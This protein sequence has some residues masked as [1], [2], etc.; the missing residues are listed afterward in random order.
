MTALVV[1]ATRTIDVG[2]ADDDSIDIV[3]GPIQ[4]KTH[5]TF[6]VLSQIIRHYDPLAA[7]VDLHSLFL[8]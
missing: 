3:L 5:T 4:T 7:D 1:A 8:R 2:E 6:D